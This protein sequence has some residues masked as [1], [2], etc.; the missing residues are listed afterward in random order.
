MEENK[1]GIMPINKLVVYMSV[2]LMISMLTQ[3]LYNFVDSFFVAQIENV[4]QSAITA[5]SLVLPFQMFII[6]ITIGTGIGISSMISRRLGEK[7]FEGA[8]FIVGN[9]LF[10]AIFTSLIFIFFGN[11]LIRPYFEIQTTSNLIINLGVKYFC[12]IV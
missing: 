8:N 5:L 12:L 11:F 2:P 9:S 6:A 7:N 3:A 1:L 10:I 4:G